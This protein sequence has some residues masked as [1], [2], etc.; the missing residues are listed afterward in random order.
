[1][2]GVILS[3]FILY[4]ILIFTLSMIVNIHIVWIIALAIG[5]MYGI[6]L[7][8]WNTF[9]AR[10]IK[11]DEQEETWRFLSTTLLND[12]AII[13]C[14]LITT[15]RTIFKI[16]DILSPGTVIFLPVVPDDAGYL[17]ANRRKSYSKLKCILK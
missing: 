6:L 15:D 2:Y 14:E 10:F 3:G 11:S 9:M 13:S 5:L 16:I 7:P 8:A 12:R 17:S 4:M 1:M